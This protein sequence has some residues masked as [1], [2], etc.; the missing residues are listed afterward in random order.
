M[1]ASQYTWNW[2]TK[3]AYLP[4]M[5]RKCWRRWNQIIIPAKAHLRYKMQDLTKNVQLRLLAV[6]NCYSILAITLK[7]TI[8]SRSLNIMQKL[9]AHTRRR[10]ILS[11]QLKFHKKILIQNK[12][13]PLKYQKKMNFTL[14][15][16]SLMKQQKCTPPSSHV[17][18]RSAIECSSNQATSVTM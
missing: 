9:K 15:K 2:V 3:V 6:M 13:T 12:K 14:L 18:T 4:A 5:E 11:Q 1:K 7:I 10:V 17:F 16:R 8:L